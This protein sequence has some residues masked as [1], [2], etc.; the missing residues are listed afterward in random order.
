MSIQ[1]YEAISFKDWGG[2]YAIMKPENDGQWVSIQDYQ[3]L[4]DTLIYMRDVIATP[5]E[6]N[7]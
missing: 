2:S 3:S 4:L 6:E 7:Q 1:R 5:H